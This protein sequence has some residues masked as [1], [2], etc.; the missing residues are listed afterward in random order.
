MEATTMQNEEQNVQFEAKTSDYSNKVKELIANGSKRI[1]GVKVKNVNFT[2]MSEQ[3]K[4]YT[5]VSF[6]LCNKV[7]GFIM[8]N[9]TGDYKE[10][11]TNIIYTSLYAIVG[12]IKEDEELAWLGNHLLN[13][14]Q[15]LPILFAGSYIDLIQTKINA[16][17]NYSNPFSTKENSTP[18]V[19]DHDVIINNI[20]KFNLGKSGKMA[21]SRLMDKLLGF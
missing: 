18:Q 19:F 3:G 13:N 8:D 20:I 9:E 2:D 15:I 7:E 16:G 4:D 21:T 12:A 6:T 10:G 5:M 1:N 14:P 11:L 17:E